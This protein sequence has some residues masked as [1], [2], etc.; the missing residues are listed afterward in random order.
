MTR[1]LLVEDNPG[2]AVIFRETLDGSE[3]DYDL[4]HA[5]RLGEGLEHLGGAAFDILM[6]DLSL[7]D[8]Q[9]METVGQVRDAAPDVPLIVLTG[10]DDAASAAEA[11]R[12]GAV[13]YLVKWYVD[14]TSLARY[15]RYAIAQY[16]IERKRAADET[17]AEPSPAPPPAAEEPEAERPPPDPLPEPGTPEPADPLAGPS[18]PQADGLLRGAAECALAFAERSERRSAW[19]ADV[20]RSAL[21][22]H[23]VAAGEVGVQ[24]EGVDVLDLARQAAAAQ[25]GLAMQCG[26]PLHVDSER[27]KVMAQADRNLV[28]GTLR[29]LV[30][31]A[32]Q[33]ADAAGVELRVG[34]EG[35][36]AVVEA[37]W[38][39]SRAS[40]DAAADCVALGRSV[41]EQT[42]RLA[43]GEAL[44][45]GDASGRHV[46]TLRLPGP[47]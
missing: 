18:T 2:D 21:D 10:L 20:L 23:R 17:V 34:V 43:G 9:G 27:K 24:P 26:V 14:S 15:I 32:L 3:L 42:M 44:R 29:R 40:L 33:A 13:D 35:P 30:V 36:Q 1:I 25:R 37:V 16:E 8:A 7:P 41:V 22:L 5:Q 6:V 47:A 39:E 4:V 19:M 31:D 45:Q 38:T 11:K 28:T 46:L 12:L